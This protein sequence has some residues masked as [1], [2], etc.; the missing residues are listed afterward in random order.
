[1]TRDAKSSPRVVCKLNEHYWCYEHTVY[2]GGRGGTAV[3][4]YC[5][6]CGLEQVG[7]VTHWRKVRKNEFE[8]PA[9]TLGEAVVSR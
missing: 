5:E 4:R 7:R 6:D 3:R 9:K 1:M 2:S 8:H